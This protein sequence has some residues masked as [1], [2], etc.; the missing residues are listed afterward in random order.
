[1]TSEVLVSL[2]VKASPERAFDVFTRD[3]AQWWKT[4]GLFQFTP[5][6]PDRI[7]FDPGEG[8]RLTETLSNGKVF[9]IGR[10]SV[11]QPVAVGGRRRFVPAKRPKSR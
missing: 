1:M 9:E 4:N 7:A 5:R 2:R 10:I 6:S 8:G 3:I 11:W